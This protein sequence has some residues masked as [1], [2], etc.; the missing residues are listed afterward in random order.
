MSLEEIIKNKSD[1]ISIFSG[2][3]ITDFNMKNPFVKQRSMT[4]REIG[5]MRNLFNKGPCKNSLVK[6]PDKSWNIGGLSLNI[7]RDNLL[8]KGLYGMLSYMDG[9]GGT[10][11]ILTPDSQW[12]SKEN[13]DSLGG[14]INPLIERKQWGTAF[15]DA[16][17]KLKD[18]KSG[19]PFAITY[20][21]SVTCREIPF[22][23]RVAFGTAMSE[24]V[25]S[26]VQIP[27]MGDNRDHYFSWLYIP[28]DGQYSNLT[29]T[30]WVNMFGKG[31][32]ERDYDRFKQIRKFL[33]EECEKLDPSGNY[34][35]IKNPQDR[36]S[37]DGETGD[38][39]PPENN[40]KEANPNEKQNADN[41]A[42]NNKT[43][44]GNLLVDQA[45]GIT[46]NAGTPNAGTS[47]A[48]TDKKESHVVK[49]ALYNARKFISEV[50]IREAGR[51]YQSS[52]EE[53]WKGEPYSNKLEMENN[54]PKYGPL[55]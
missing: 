4:Y 43:P 9:E 22:F 47:N 21:A 15:N 51:S 35:D 44:T 7:V 6:A 46:P 41:K 34:S 2:S 10:I 37:Q 8:K 28:K 16:N 52:Q 40:N 55:Y 50:Y 39:A 54:I 29:P 36:Y 49:E 12:S 19:G 53:W 17:A 20:V 42:P 30:D 14:I 5:K 23:G 25:I 1:L 3:G 18:S 26:L 31:G 13:I 11:W 38:Q 33:E 24:G 48:G 27:T 45:N 32:T